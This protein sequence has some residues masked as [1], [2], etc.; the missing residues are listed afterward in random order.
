MANLGAV[1]RMFGPLLQLVCLSMLVRAKRG[2]QFLGYPVEK[3]AWLGVLTGLVLVAVGVALSRLRKS[4]KNDPIDR[5]LK[6]R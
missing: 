3:V 5:P 4:V 6:L 2:D 1:L